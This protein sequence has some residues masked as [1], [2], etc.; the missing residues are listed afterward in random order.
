MVHLPNEIWLQ[1]ASYCEARDLWLALRPVSRQLLRCSEQ[2]FKE[3]FL[4]KAVLHLRIRIPTYDMRNPLQSRITFR[5]LGVQGDYHH[6][7]LPGRYVSRL[8][9][10]LVETDPAYY[11]SHFLSRWKG[12]Q[13][14]QGGR[15]SD[16]MT[17]ELDLCGEHET[18]ALCARTVPV[19]LQN[20]VAESHEN[21]CED[22]ARL[23]FEWMAT[24][25][26]FFR[27]LG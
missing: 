12:M 14:S 19:H 27:N 7:A 15:L 1:I 2:Q 26:S 3:E 17:W 24:V 18:S 9:F 13:D 10:I 20:P 23:S 16:K 6:N 21:D 5:P 4:T 22:Q 8:T 25:T 11:Q